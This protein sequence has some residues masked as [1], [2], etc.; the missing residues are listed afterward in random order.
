MT[1]IKSL[2]TLTIIACFASTSFAQFSSIKNKI[3]KYQKAQVA[4]VE[5]AANQAKEG[6]QKVITANNKVYILLVDGQ[7]AGWRSPRLNE[8]KNRKQQK[9]EFLYALNLRPSPTRGGR[10]GDIRFKPKRIDFSYLKEDTKA[11]QEG[12]I[13]RSTLGDSR[14]NPGFKKTR[15][16]Y[17]KNINLGLITFHPYQDH[18]VVTDTLFVPVA[19]AGHALLYGSYQNQGMQKIKIIANCI[20]FESPITLASTSAVSTNFVFSANKYIYKSV[21]KG[22]DRKISSAP[23]YYRPEYRNVSGRIDKMGPDEENLLN[24]LYFYNMEQILKRLHNSNLSD[25]INEKLMAEFQYYKLHKINNAFLTQNQRDGLASEEAQVMNW[26][27]VN[28]MEKVRTKL[29][30]TENIWEKDQLF[31]EF[32]TLRRQKVQGS[33]LIEDPKTNNLFNQSCTAFDSQYGSNEVEDARD[34]NGLKILV[35]GTVDD[36]PGQSFK[37]YTLPTKAN[38]LPSNNQNTGKTTAL[39]TI[40][41]NPTGDS[42]LELKMEVELTFDQQAF[43]KAKKTLKS[44]G[45]ELEDKFPGHLASIEEQVLKMNGKTIGD[46]IPIGNQNVRFEIQLAND[47]L[48]LL[49]LF[50]NHIQFKV[51]YHINR[52]LKPYRQDIQLNI[53]PALLG[54][55][56]PQQPLESFSV[57]DHSTMTDIIKISSFLDGQLTDE[58]ALNYV[59]ISLE[60][61]FENNKV[62]HGPFRLSSAGTLASH[63]VIEFLK[64]SENYSVTVSG[65]AFY[66]N[67][68]REIETFKTTRQIINRDYYKKI[69]TARP[70]IH[71]RPHEADH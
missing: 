65:Q 67:G 58:E 55:L 51:D 45:L 9:A 22:L 68:R 31:V 59:E 16:H 41:Y 50:Q 42:E 19:D 46:I 25:E 36:L 28:S 47:G 4:A 14:L 43:E 12:T 48:T 23:L 39:G 40:H 54:N 7:K 44:Y 8:L 62:F 3:Q 64:H 37:Y 24:R 20:I 61:N 49:Q 15:V 56:D 18:I 70:H 30:E 69:Q 53:D 27:Y 17:F 38:L 11:I 21:H 35:D 52:Q 13:E 10:T 63:K 1:T 29:N 32:Q 34:L 26:L 6:P 71:M 60:I 66:E 2:L 5:K 57:I 33:I